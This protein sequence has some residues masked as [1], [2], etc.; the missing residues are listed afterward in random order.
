MAV[1]FK[2]IVLEAIFVVSSFACVERSSRRETAEWR[3]L[4]LGK[5]LL[6]KQDY[7]PKILCN[8]SI[9]CSDLWSKVKLAAAYQPKCNFSI[10]AY[11]DFVTASQ[12]F[13]P[14]NK[15]LFWEGVYPFVMW[16]SNSGNKYYTISDTLTGYLFDNIEWCGNSSEHDG[17]EK[18]PSTCPGYELGPDCQKS[19]QSV[20]WE[21]A[22][23]F[24]AR[25]AY[26]DV[27]VML[28]ASISPAFPT[29]SE[30]CSSESIKNLQG[31]FT[32]KGISPSCIDNPRDV[33]MLMCSE[34]SSN[35]NC[36]IT[37]GANRSMMT[38][39]FIFQILCFILLNIFV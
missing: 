24:Y 38:P 35:S 23:L 14:E 10:S 5:C 21:T 18:Y 26:G 25:H 19:A 9:D 33:Q 8:S 7:G 20:F 17:I 12:H 22:S 37:S 34:N 39:Y 30:T 15:F 6:Y 36:R 29:D 4:F 11:E 28:N 27:H 13:V 2:S 32:E 3:E 31:R 16:Y 1:V